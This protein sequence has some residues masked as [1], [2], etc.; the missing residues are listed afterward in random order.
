MVDDVT[1]AS[2]HGQHKGRGGTHA[3]GGFQFLGNAHERAKTEDLYQH[4]VVDQNRAD[5]DE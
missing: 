3:I 4:D 1:G 2:G 5:E